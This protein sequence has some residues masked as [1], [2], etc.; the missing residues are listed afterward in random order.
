[1]RECTHRATGEALA[2]KVLHRRRN[3]ADRTAAILAE[4][5]AAAAIAAAAP[6]RAAR[7]VALHVD[8][9]CAYLV[10]EL[11]VGGS[12]Q[13]LLDARAASGSGS[14]VAADGGDEGSAGAGALSEAEAAAALAGALE[15]LAACHE[16]GFCYGGE[17]AERTAC[18]SCV[19]LPLLPLSL[20][21]FCPVP[22]LGARL[23]TTKHS[24]RLNKHA[25]PCYQQHTNAR[26]N[27]RRQAQQLYA[28]LLIPFGRAP[29]RPFGSQRAPRRAP[30][31]LRH[32]AALRLGRRPAG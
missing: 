27:N 23:P 24:Q 31:R 28:C 32:R 13:A 25:Q 3:R 2:V 14:G 11:L 17:R 15:A 16:A 22:L 30:R 6:A 18:F 19:T 7:V 12:L 10:Q 29:G 9:H 20:P 8:S 26:Q 5:D 1:M 21:T 4:L